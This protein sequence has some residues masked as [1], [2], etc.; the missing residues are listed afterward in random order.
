MKEEK[1]KLVVVGI[2]H[3]TSSISNLEL[4]QLNKNEIADALHFLKAKEEVEGVVIIFSCNRIE[5]YLT[6]KKPIDPFIIIN[7]YFLENK[8]IDASKRKHSFYC[9]K[10]AEAAK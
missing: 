1:L 10:N 7:N 3:K 5:F 2:S 6:L 9:Y 4:F 8:K